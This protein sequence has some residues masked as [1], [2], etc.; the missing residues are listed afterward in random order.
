MQS[1]IYINLLINVSDS[2]NS[3]LNS[4]DEEEISL[5]SRDL[6]NGIPLW[7]LFTLSSMILF[8]R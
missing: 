2:D 8:T 1:C 6:D 3:R 7:I 5:G 4:S